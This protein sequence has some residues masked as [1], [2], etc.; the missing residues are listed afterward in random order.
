MTAPATGASPDVIDA[1]NAL[2]TGSRDGAT[3][4]REAADQVRSP[5]V[6]AV[7]LEHAAENDRHALEMEAEIRR[8]G[9]DPDDGGKLAAKARRLAQGVMASVTDRDDTAILSQVESGLDQAER[10]YAQALRQPLAAETQALVRRQWREMAA[11]HNRVAELLRQDP[12]K[13]QG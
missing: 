5:Q 13:A 12:G 9:G 7:L 8:L 10:T 2:L 1:L 6:K 11:Q 4:D 3:G